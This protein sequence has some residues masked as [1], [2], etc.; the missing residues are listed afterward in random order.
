MLRQ[1]SDGISQ[2]LPASHLKACR[3][4]EPRLAGAIGMLRVEQIVH[5]LRFADDSSPRMRKLHGKDDPR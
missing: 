1:L 3:Q 2:N 4:E 5:D